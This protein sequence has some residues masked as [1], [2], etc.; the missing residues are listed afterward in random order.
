M[1]EKKNYQL[2]AWTH[3]SEYDGEL[4]VRMIPRLMLE[5]EEPYFKKIGRLFQELEK[6]RDVSQEMADV[7]EENADFMFRTGRYGD[8]IRMLCLAATACTWN[9]N[10]EFMDTDL[11]SYD[12]LYGKTRHDF[13][14]LY[15]RFRKA[16]RKYGRDDIMLEENS[17]RLEELFS[18][19]TA[20]DRSLSQHL[21]EMRCW[22]TKF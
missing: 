7:Y 21:S 16:I 22:K 2:V 3:R 17:K 10:W 6:G 13:F 18:C 15:G 14:R 9:D 19:I 12:W 5:I 20:M 1:M 11:G 8:G 4:E